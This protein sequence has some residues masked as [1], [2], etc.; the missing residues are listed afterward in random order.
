MLL[1]QG[2]NNSKLSLYLPLIH[3]NLLRGS[4][5]FVAITYFE[6]NEVKI[7]ESDRIPTTKPEET[8]PACVSFFKKFQEKNGPLKSVGIAS[9]GPVELNESSPK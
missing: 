5:I 3:T 8:L 1:K 6:N 4:K 7:L 9:F 2:K